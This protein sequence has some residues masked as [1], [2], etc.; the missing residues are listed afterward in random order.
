LAKVS[1]QFGLPA[2]DP[3]RSGVGAIVDNLD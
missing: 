2:V 1:R 3:V